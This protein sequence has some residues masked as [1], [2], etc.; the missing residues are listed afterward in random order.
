MIVRVLAIGRVKG[1]LREAAE[2]YHKRAS[3]YW[4]LEVSDLATPKGDPDPNQVRERESRRIVARLDPAHRLVVLTRVG[5]PMGSRDLARYLSDAALQSTPGVTF[6]IGGAYGL[7]P[8]LL[9][10]ASR[11]LSLSHMTLPHDLA[12]VVLLEQLYRAGTIRRGEP[13]HKGD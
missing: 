10:R 2:A 12:R 7:A 13:Y 4:R 9:E 11:K 3:R 1:A 5:R 6:V 8:E